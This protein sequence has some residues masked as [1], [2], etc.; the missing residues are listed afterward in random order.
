MCFQLGSHSAHNTHSPGRPTSQYLSPYST[1]TWHRPKSPSPIR[2]HSSNASQDQ[3]QFKVAQRS[4]SPGLDH[5]YNYPS[6]RSPTRKSADHYKVRGV[7]NTRNTVWTD[8]SLRYSKK[9][10][11]YKADSYA[12]AHKS[13]GSYSG[14]CKYRHV[15]L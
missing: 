3:S 15:H 9:A 5:Y 11:S 2:Y 6:E 4:L 7:L 8:L 1:A 12:A 13:G 14:L 10:P